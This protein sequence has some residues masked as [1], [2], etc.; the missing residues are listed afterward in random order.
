[1]QLG[2]F[3]IMSAYCR[4]MSDVKLNHDDDNENIQACIKLQTIVY[5]TSN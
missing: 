3:A 5:E 4:Q 2:R 1:M